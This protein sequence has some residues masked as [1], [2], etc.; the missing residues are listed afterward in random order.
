M[1]CAVWKYMLHV[2]ATCRYTRL[3]K[4]LDMKLGNLGLNPGLTNDN[5]VTFGK[6]G[7]PGD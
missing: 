1:D 5:C 2:S 3:F 6:L 7:F 4:G